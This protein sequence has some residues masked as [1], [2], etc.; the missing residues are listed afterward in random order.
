M[1]K[2]NVPIIT[3]TEI[4]AR[5]MKTIET[6]IEEIQKQAQKV[7]A[8]ADLAVPLKEKLEVLKQMYRIETG[9]EY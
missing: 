8:M 6:E 9:N 1:A 4:L 7:P 5:A 2:K 3:H